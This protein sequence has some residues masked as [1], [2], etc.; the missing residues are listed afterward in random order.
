LIGRRL[1][2]NYLAGTAFGPASTV[3]YQTVVAYLE[4]AQQV[5]LWLGLILLAC[6]WFASANRSGTAVRGTVTGGLERVGAALPDHMP[7]ARWADN[8]GWLRDAIAGLGLV[9]LL[10]LVVLQVLVGADPTSRSAE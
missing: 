2:V 6:G 9:V 5:A 10:L 7:V 4:R 3:M 1:F 8:I